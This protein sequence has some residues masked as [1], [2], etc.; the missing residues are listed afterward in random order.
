MPVAGVTEV[1]V[2]PQAGQGAGEVGSAALAVAGARREGGGAQ[3]DA[4]RLLLL[5]GD[6]ELG[7]GVDAVDDAGRGAEPA[8][9]VPVGDAEQ[10]GGA[11]VDT[12]EPVVDGIA[13]EETH[14]PGL[15]VKVSRTSRVMIDRRFR[16]TRRRWAPRA[17]GWSGEVPAGRGRPPSQGVRPVKVVSERL[18]HASATITLGIYADVMPGMQAQAAAKF[19][20]LIARGAS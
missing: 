6:D 13:V 7:G 20:A 10:A 8:G 18:G 5:Q 11:A 12:V 2:G 15:A 4:V 9:G 1:D 19:G 17:R 3:V 14:R 16:T